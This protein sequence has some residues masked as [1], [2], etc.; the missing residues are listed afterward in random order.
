MF[1]YGEEAWFELS[2]SNFGEYI[3]YLEEVESKRWLYLFNFKCSG[4]GTY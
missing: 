1:L 2:L 4:T 3:E